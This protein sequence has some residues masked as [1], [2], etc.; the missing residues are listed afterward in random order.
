[1]TP[2]RIPFREFLTAHTARVPPLPCVDHEV[3]CEV[4]L[5]PECP[6]TKAARVR[7]RVIEVQLLVA[8]QAGRVPEVLATDIALVR[9]LSC[10][11]PLVVDE[12]VFVGEGLVA[13]WAGEGPVTAVHSLVIFHGAPNVSRVCAVGALQPPRWLFCM[14]IK[15]VLVEVFR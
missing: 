4:R 3:L 1:M 11:H 10:V 14:D 9:L 12:V 6:S 5:Q 8:P 15:Y 7:L 2:R 13:R